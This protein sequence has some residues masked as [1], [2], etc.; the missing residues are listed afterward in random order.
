MLRAVWISGCTVGRGSPQVTS[1]RLTTLTP[2]HVDIFLWLG[3]L[4]LQR[5][6][7]AAV[8]LQRWKARAL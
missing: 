5:G 1:Q 7:L 8:A 6:E 2:R 3:T 4:D